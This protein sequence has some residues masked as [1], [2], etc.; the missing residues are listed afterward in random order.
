M[1]EVKKEQYSDVKTLLHNKETCCPTFVYSILEQT[2]SGVVY[3]D[4]QSFLIG[5]S[6]GIYYVAGDE[7]NQNCNELIVDLYKRKTESKKRF[8]LFSSNRSWDSVIR[9]V[10]HDELSQMMRYAFS[11]Q[12]FAKKAFQLPKGFTLKRINEDIISS[13]TEFQ[14]AYYEEYWGSVSNFLKNG[15]GFAVLYD[16]HVVSECTSIFLGGNRAEMDIYTR[17]EYRGMG[18]AY[19]AGSKFINDC[20]ENG[21]SPS[22]DCDVSNKSSILSAKKLGFEISTKYSIFFKKSG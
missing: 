18:F 8:T 11:Q 9:T 14:K 7:R 3:A 10:L 22:W 21:V 19:I 2:I 16:N 4:D 1:Q 13:S 15:F 6:S 20:L 5:T 17:E 12:I